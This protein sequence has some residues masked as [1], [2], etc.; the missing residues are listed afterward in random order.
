MRAPILFPA[1]LSACFE[2]QIDVGTSEPADPQNTQVQTNPG[3]PEFDIDLFVANLDEKFADVAG[4]QLVVIEDGRLHEAWPVGNATWAPDPE[5]D[6]ALDMDERMTV[7]SVSKFIGTI[8]LMDVLEAEGI[9]VD[10]P[11]RPYLPPTWRDAV[12]PDHD[13]GSNWAVTFEGL[14]TMDTALAFPSGGSTSPGRHS[15]N[16]EMLQALSS[17]AAPGRWGS[18]QNGN[19][20]LLRI[21]IGELVYDLDETAPGYTDELVAQV[22]EDHLN[23]NV[24]EP[25]GIPSVGH[26]RP[27]GSVSRAYQY[28]IDTGFSDGSGNVGW[29]P[30][31]RWPVTAGSTELY[32]TALELAEV[33][34][35]FAH[36]DAG[37]LLSVEQRETMLDL[38]LGLTESVTGVH[39]RY[40]SK[41]GGR[42]PDGSSRGYRSRVMFYPNGVEAVVITNSYVTALGPWLRDA[43]DDAWVTP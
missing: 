37:T 26:V 8:A 32:L 30:S 42:G 19:F 2:L 43:F 23:D 15:S 21:L 27:A 6:V 12:H 33:S 20:T 4:A 39:G 7:A 16:A 11:I 13:L 1:L 14:L 35:Y 17:P 38:E 34:A 10:E 3:L 40:P 41:Q 22:Y 25:L 29:L 9:D 28:P 36:D 18:Y 31:D 5:G 24:F